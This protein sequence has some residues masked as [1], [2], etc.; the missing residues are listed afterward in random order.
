MRAGGELELRLDEVD[1][2]DLLGHRVLDLQPRV[3]LDEGEAASPVVAASTRNSNVPALRYFAA[4]A[5]SV[6]APQQ[7]LRARRPSRTGAGAIS[8][9]FWW[10]ALHAAVALAEVR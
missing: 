10:R 8:T 6:A 3:G 2:G 9:S 5:S 7:A 4:A 1:A